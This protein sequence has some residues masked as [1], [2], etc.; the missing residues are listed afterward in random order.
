MKKHRYR[1][2]LEH[3]SDADGE[4]SSQAPL[5]FEVGN[6]DEIIAIVERLRSRGDFDAT[7]AAAFGVGL[8]LFS[9]VMLDNRKNPLFAS[10]QPHFVQ[11]M[12]RLKHPEQEENAGKAVAVPVEKPQG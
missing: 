10:F 2:T 11:F 4:P 8:K 3:L 7:T 1:V 12:K 9:E 5:Q 6:H